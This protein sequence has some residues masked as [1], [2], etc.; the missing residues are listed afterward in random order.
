[1]TPTLPS[2]LETPSQQYR[3]AST[4][5]L[6]PPKTSPARFNYHP[7]SA[8]A[9][10][11]GLDP[12]RPTEP[13]RGAIDFTEI[14]LDKGV[15][16]FAF[17]MIYVRDDHEH[18]I[19]SN[20]DVNVEASYLQ[21]SAKTSI[22][23]RNESAFNSTSVTAVARL[24]VD[25]GRWGLP[26]SAKLTPEASSLLATDPK[27]FAQIYGTHYAAIENRGATLNATITLSSVS[28][29]FKSKFELEFSGKGGWGGFSASASAMFATEAQRASKQNRISVDVSGAAG[30]NDFAFLRKAILELV[31][32]EEDPWKAIQKALAEAVSS[33]DKNSAPPIAYTIASMADF[34]LDESI[35]VPW[36]DKKA[37]DLARLKEHWVVLSRDLQVIDEIEAKKHPLSRILDAKLISFYI[38]QRPAGLERKSFLQDQHAACLDGRSYVVPPRMT[39]LHSLDWRSLDPPRVAFTTASPSYRFSA[40]EIDLLIH[41]PVGSRLDKARRLSRDFAEETITVMYGIELLRPLLSWQLIAKVKDGDTLIWDEEPWGENFYI[42]WL[43]EPASKNEPMEMFFRRWAS[44]ARGSYS[45]EISYRLRDKL[46]GSY[47]YQFM[48]LKWSVSRNGTL[49]SYEWKILS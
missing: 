34:G 21:Y 1:M 2:R 4:Q 28:Q 23:S 20:I 38:S 27:K 11:R 33:F 32:V 9:L 46:G 37:T 29:S 3:T 36:E 30:T 24:S 19:A 31:S 25:Y 26:A 6:L 43:H 5:T 48:T 35:L 40:D 39:L 7:E 14:A 47:D 10:G 18:R 17:S 13:K 49:E 45:A 42:P 44:S 41:S 12:I 16:A 22:R 8:I 15:P